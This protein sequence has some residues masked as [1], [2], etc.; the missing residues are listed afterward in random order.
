MLPDQY[1]GLKQDFR[2]DREAG[3]LGG[4]KIDDQLELGRPFSPRWRVCWAT[5]EVLATD[6]LPDHL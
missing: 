4:L 2:W 6:M 5:S 1:I 3:L